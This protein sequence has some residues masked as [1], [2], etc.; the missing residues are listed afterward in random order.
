MAKVKINL[1]KA[2]QIGG[3]SLEG[4]VE[5]DAPTVGTMI[6]AGELCSPANQ[7]G[8]SVAT[9]AVVLGKPYNA[10]RAMPPDAFLSLQEDLKEILPN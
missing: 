6:D 8:Y 5:V 3:D 10:L 2:Y 9:V 7:V 4:M 1:S